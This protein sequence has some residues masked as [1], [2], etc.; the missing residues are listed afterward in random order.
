MIKKVFMLVLLPCIFALSCTSNTGPGTIAEPDDKS[1]F[2]VD[3][4]SW[5]YNPPQDEGYFF[6]IGCDPDKNEA[7]EKAFVNIAQQF[8]TKVVSTL[9]NQHTFEAAG[10]E[11]SI[12]SQVDHQLT[13][14]RVAGAKIFDS[15]KDRADVSWILVKAPANCSL[16]MAEGVLLSYSL[17]QRITPKEI[18]AVVDEIESVIT[19]EVDTWYRN[20][21]F[22][23]ELVI[24]P[25]GVI[26]ID[27]KTDD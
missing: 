15:Y 6:G 14:I 4:P 5:V 1:T 9:K 7:K 19:R 25:D 8:Q 18:N 22:S 12:L 16:D 20:E 21:E 24:V 26:K 2:G 23:W 27:G 10:D 3:V 11:E 13:D 17:E